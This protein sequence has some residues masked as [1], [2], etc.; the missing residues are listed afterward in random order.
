MLWKALLYRDHRETVLR[1]EYWIA[2]FIILKEF[3]FMVLLETVVTVKCIWVMWTVVDFG[4][5]FILSSFLHFIFRK[6]QHKQKKS[7]QNHLKRWNTPVSREDP[8]VLTIQLPLGKKAFWQ[9]ESRCNVWSQGG[10]QKQVEKETKETSEKRKNIRVLMQDIRS[11][12][13]I[14]KGTE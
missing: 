1:S 2:L 12:M 5:P 7:T 9:L 6:K 10:Q 14:L 8:A 11:L 3:V 4:T 13:I